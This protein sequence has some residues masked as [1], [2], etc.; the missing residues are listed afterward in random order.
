[1]G[2]FSQFW[3]YIRHYFPQAGLRHLHT[4]LALLIIIQIINSNFIHMTHEGVL[5]DTPYATAFLWFHIIAGLLAVVCTVAM[6]TYMLS[7]QSFRQF[8]PY[9]F[10]DNAV[11]KDDLAQL[12]RMK[13]PEPRE[14]GLGN[15]VQG[16]GIGALILI[17]VAAVAWLVLWNM[18]S[19][20]AN[21][22]REIHKALT[23]LIEAYLI[24]H[25]GM[26]LLHFIV[27]RKRFA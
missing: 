15:I 2:I 18:H 21:E 27:E 22:V 12:A 16:L 19:P 8:F 23:G 25:G 9:L 5:K 10:G 4:S 20:Y 11:L 17:E 14:K 24:G 13:L 6:V 3:R 26:A 1:M 7:R